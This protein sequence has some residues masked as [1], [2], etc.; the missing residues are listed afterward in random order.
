MSALQ[1]GTARGRRDGAR[2]A[3]EPSPP[4]PAAAPDQRTATERDA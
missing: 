1:A 4:E 3:A 2:R